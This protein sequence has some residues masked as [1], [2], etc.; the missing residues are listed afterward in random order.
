L[1]APRAPASLDVS[2]LTAP[3]AI[4][5]EAL[6]SEVA[7][8]VTNAS[9]AW[10]DNLEIVATAADGGLPVRTSIPLIAPV[11]A[12]KI[13]F[14]I[15]VPAPRLPGDVAIDVRLQ[16]RAT[17]P[18][19]APRILDQTQLKLR[20]CKPG[21]PRRCTFRSRI[22][23]SVQYYGLIP[24]QAD[25]S[26]TPACPPGL[27][28]TLHGA[29]VEAIGQ[30]QAY[31]AKPGLVIVAPT[32]RRPY[33]FDWEDWGRLDALEVLDRA[34]ERYHIDRARVYL[35][36]H[37]M[38]GH[39]TWHIGTTYPD[40]FAA[41][42]PSAGWV[43]MFSYAG[44]APPQPSGS[45][46]RL[47]ASAVSPS[48]TLGLVQNLASVGVYVL[49]GDADDNVPV[50]QARAMRKA[51]GEFHPDFVYHEQPGAGHWWGNLCVDWPP[52]FA[53]LRTRSIPRPEDL[54][55]LDF[56]TASPGVSSRMHWASIEAVVTPSANCQ[57]HLEREREGRRV[58]GTTENV[59]RL[60]I[61]VDQCFGKSDPGRVMTI[62]LDGQTL[63]GLKPVLKDRPGVIVLVRAGKTWSSLSEPI[64]SLHKTPE[65]MGPFKAAFRD[66]FV[67]VVGTRGSAEE[68]AWALARARFDAETFWYRG[69]GGVDLVRDVDFNAGSQ[70]FHD[71]GVILY[72]DRRSNA[73]W[74]ILLG[75]SPVQVERGRVR[76]GQR[77]LVGDDLAC[78]LVR[79]RPDGKG[80]VG[81]V[82]GSGMRGLRM[83][84]LIP[85][86]VS[87]VGYPDCMVLRAN[88]SGR[89]NQA[90][91]A[92]G[93]FGNDWGVELG[94]FAYR[95]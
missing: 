73:A 47:M 38:G 22:D 19:G 37:S 61:D 87:G 9:T 14:G 68:N 15:K 23:G 36:G 79:P 21:D 25:G 71:R 41:I 84:E 85:Y 89:L 60:A 11:S 67:L 75:E 80:H 34:L 43:S 33:G 57:I 74:P 81:V 45:I 72:G 78:V 3:D 90:L 95:D 49:H 32:N 48:D 92:A 4:V 13:G 93:Y 29:S 30:A 51:L 24:A 27:V 63:T 53:F 76:I 50:S 20:V 35:T 77:E 52:L 2:D 16:E 26:E 17:L 58:R 55:R 86:F 28:L 94:E 65:R 56:I 44:M 46:E 6:D 70:V 54:R 91:V 39:G 8:V 5:G 31:A 66:H 82:A 64:R 18:G 69:N 10:R 83:T 40:R 1:L 88:G 7:L 42:A 12:R 59:A 62:A